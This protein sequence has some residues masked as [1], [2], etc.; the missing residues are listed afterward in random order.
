MRFIAVSITTMY[1][2][3]LLDM[4]CDIGYKLIKASKEPAVP[5]FRIALIL[6]QVIILYPYAWMGRGR[7]RGKAV[8]KLRLSVHKVEQLTN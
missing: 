2:T 4:M 1:I 7:P 8:N 6:I 5:F 3:V